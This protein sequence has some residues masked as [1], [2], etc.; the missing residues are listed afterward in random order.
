MKEY[1]PK[2][3]RERLDDAARHL[4]YAEQEI[5]TIRK[6]RTLT[7]SEQVM[8]WQTRIAAIQSEMLETIMEKPDRT[9]S[10]GERPS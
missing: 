10:A 8:D 4:G 2:E 3:H 1:Y 9:Q 7:A 6:T 5:E